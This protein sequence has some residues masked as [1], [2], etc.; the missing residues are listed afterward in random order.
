MDTHGQLMSRLES[1]GT[2]LAAHEQDLTALLDRQPATPF[3]VKRAGR[4]YLGQVQA[5]ANLFSMV[6]VKAGVPPLG[7]WA[8][9]ADL[10]VE[11]VDLLLEQRP[12][13]VVEAGSGVSTLF[14]AL[15]TEHH[16]LPVRIVAL[17][18][19][20]SYLV[21]TRALLARHGVSH[22]AEVRHAPLIPSSIEG[23]ATPWY[24]E[25][26]LD[27]LSD[28]G[29]VLVDGPPEATGVAARFPLVPLMQ[30]RFAAQCTI[31]IDDTD[32]AG[33]R[34][35]VERWRALLPDFGYAALPFEKGAVVLRRP[36]TMRM[37]EGALDS[38]G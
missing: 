31:L 3:Q 21:K 16:D 22:R 24:D 33:D 28:V 14:L 6:P 5:T 13:V 4:T 36:S 38:W 25:R 37:S 32:R 35:V 23:H 2:S 9:S 34:D 26:A 20:E 11:L 27:D 15:A 7:Q 10:L 29:L 17:E 8:A 18:H 12:R 1:H 30:E 19:D